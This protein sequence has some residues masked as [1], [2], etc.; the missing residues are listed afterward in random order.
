MKKLI[1]K[2]NNNDSVFVIISHKE[3]FGKNHETIEEFKN[4]FNDYGF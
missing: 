1:V 3:Q 2:N 4:N